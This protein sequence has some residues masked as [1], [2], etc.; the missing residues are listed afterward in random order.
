VDAAKEDGLALRQVMYV[1]AEDADETCVRQA[2]FFCKLAQGRSRERL[3]CFDGARGH[4]DAGGGVLKEQDLGAGAVAA[5]AKDG[6]LAL[7]LFG[8]HERRLY[9]R[10]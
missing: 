8:R 6:Y 9:Q 1:L 7:F 3:V 2:G 10:R 4:L 5:R